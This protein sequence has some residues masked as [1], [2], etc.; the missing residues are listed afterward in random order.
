MGIFELKLSTIA[1]F[2]ALNVVESKYLLVKINQRDKYEKIA[3][4]SLPLAS[5]RSNG[6]SS[7]ILLLIHFQMISFNFHFLGYLHRLVY[8]L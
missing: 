4:A 2:V 6:P 8:I 7:G 5:F 1:I 3:G